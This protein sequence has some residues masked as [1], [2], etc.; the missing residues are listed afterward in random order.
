MQRCK[1]HRIEEKKDGVREVSSS[2]V[3]DCQLMVAQFIREIDY[4]TWLSNLVM[5][6]KL[7]GKWRMCTEYMDLN[8]ASSKDV[9]PH[10]N[11][12]HLIDGA[13]KHKLLNLLDA[14]FGCNRIKMD[15]RDEDKTTI[16]TKSAN[17]CYK[18]MPFGL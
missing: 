15:Q 3:G 2:T 10:S 14:Y 12:H 9:Y 17:F 1:V 4:S 13:T 18:V 11:I 8:R 16:I 7:N 5:A 6:K